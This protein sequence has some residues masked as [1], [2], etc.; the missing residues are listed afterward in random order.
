[1]RLRT[2]LIAAVV[3]VS[4]NLGATYWSDG[5]IGITLLVLA[6]ALFAAIFLPISGVLWLIPR[7]WARRRAQRAFALASLA[8]IQ[9]VHIPLYNH[10]STVQ[11]AAAKTYVEAV[12]GVLEQQRAELGGYPLSLEGLS[13]PV[14]KPDFF[15]DHPIYHPHTDGGGGRTAYSFQ[16]RFRLPGSAPLVVHVYDSVTG[17]WSIED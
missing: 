14:A 12:V 7:D 10:I 11:L 9:L 4:V 17:N 3:S 1:M 8:S 6:A 2:W 5:N 15:S 13:V 16:F